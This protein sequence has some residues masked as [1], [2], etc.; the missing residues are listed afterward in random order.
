MNSILRRLAICAILSNLVVCT[1]AAVIERLN[2]EVNAVVEDPALQQHML[3]QGIELKGST[4]AQLQGFVEQEV[5][6]WADVI[7]A[8]H[9]EPER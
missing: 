1:P 5:A 8:A 9:I 3:E 4:P 2:R 6:K 7:H